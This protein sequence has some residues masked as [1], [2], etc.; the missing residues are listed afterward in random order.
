MDSESTII[1]KIDI[2]KEQG[3][4]EKASNFITKICQN[5]LLENK[6]VEGMHHMLS[7]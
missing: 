1:F 5:E 3:G 6:E 2:D 4:F 7:V